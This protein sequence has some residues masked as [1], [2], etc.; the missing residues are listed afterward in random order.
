[1]LLNRYA[2]T[3]PLRVDESGNTGEDMSGNMHASKYRKPS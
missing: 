2:F 1:V 3:T